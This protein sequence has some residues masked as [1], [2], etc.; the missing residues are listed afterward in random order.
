MQRIR[1]T[2]VLV[3]E[4]GDSIV[5]MVLG[6][7]VPCDTIHHIRVSS[8]IISAG[9]VGTGNWESC[10]LY[11]QVEAKETI[12]VLARITALCSMRPVFAIFHHDACAHTNILFR[13]SQA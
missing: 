11:V 2:T 6:D 10:I 13:C 3:V 7:T 12:N 8:F 9:D 4:K 5:L 1:A